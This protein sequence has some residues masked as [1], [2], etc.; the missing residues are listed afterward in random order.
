MC[1]IEV[2]SPL[3]GAL[4]FWAS[5]RRGLTALATILHAAS[6]LSRKIFGAVL[7]L[8]FPLAAIACTPR[9]TQVASPAVKTADSSPS[10][11]A[12]KAPAAVVSNARSGAYGSKP[13][14]RNPTPDTRPAPAVSFRQV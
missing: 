2:W 10:T 4:G 5:I 8:S 11:Q 7:L 3:R 6:R 14:T 12:A 9:S 1:E 13:D